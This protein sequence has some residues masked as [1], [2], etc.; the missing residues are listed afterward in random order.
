MDAGKRGNIINK[1]AK[2]NFQD[3]TSTGEEERN[4]VYLQDFPYRSHIA[5]GSIFVHTLS[6]FDD[7][8]KLFGNIPLKKK[9]LLGRR[10]WTGNEVE[11]SEALGVAG[12]CTD[13]G[14]LSFEGAMLL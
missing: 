7:T 9:K 10:H 1:G 4:N 14:R 6:K 5:G 3:P 12:I 8:R 13:K 11:T 2:L